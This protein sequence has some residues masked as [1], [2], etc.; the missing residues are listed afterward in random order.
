M[1]ILI[2]ISLI[3]FEILKEGNICNDKMN[4]IKQKIILIIKC[5]T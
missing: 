3:N 5:P 4:I 2:N 1:K